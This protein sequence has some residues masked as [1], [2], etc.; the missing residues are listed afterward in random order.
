MAPLDR[1]LDRLLPFA[2]AVAAGHGGAGA[3]S[4]TRPPTNRD[5]ERWI[6]SYL[7]ADPHSEPGRAERRQVLEQLDAVP[8]LDPRK[9]KTWRKKIHKLWRKGR[10]LETDPGDYWFWPDRD[11][12]KRGRYLVAGKTK[13]PAGLVIAMHGI[14]D[15]AAAA[16]E[17]Y[18][19]A[20]A[21]LDLLMIAPE[22]LQKQGSGWTKSGTEEFVLEL[23]DT[24]LRTWKLDSNRVFFAGHSMGGYGSWTLGGHHAD[25][26]AAIAASAGAPM[27][28]YTERGSPVVDFTEGVLPSLR[29]V[30]VSAYQS[31]DDPLM[32]PEPNQAAIARLEQ[33][34]ET[35]G[36]YAHDYWEVSGRGHTGPD[37][38]MIKQLER[39]APH[40]RNPVPE[41]IVW[42][43]VLPWK[44]QF[45]WLAWDRPISNAIVTAD[46]D[47]A[48]NTVR[49][50]TKANTEGLYVLLDRRLVDLKKPVKVALNN[51]T[52]FDGLAPIRLTTLVRTSAHP[53]PELQFVARVPA[54][55]N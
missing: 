53:D 55:A 41:R 2:L 50:T 26:V 16:K 22:V 25:R 1:F 12:A 43:P 7:T 8:P 46:L 39:A 34:A 23:V 49:I 27:P 51:E 6:N 38:G 11:G 14:D 13:K 42:Q 17:A 9:A 30:F 3:Q 31:V 54:F 48:N 21:Q 5:V 45:Y 36:G 29:N 35:W 24:A 37:G 4:K 15:H 10:R 40:V 32:P 28:I 20:C 44:Q 19:D 52:V 18:G 33:H 47:R